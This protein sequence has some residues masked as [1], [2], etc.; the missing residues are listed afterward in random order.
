MATQ[1]QIDANR[2]NARLS[3]GPKSPQGKAAVSRNAL[4]H[5]FR[6]DIYKQ[7]LVAEDSESY[8][9]LLAGLIAEHQPQP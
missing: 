7:V 4:K 9:Q 6:S 5:G 2:R 8:D 3:T 1:A